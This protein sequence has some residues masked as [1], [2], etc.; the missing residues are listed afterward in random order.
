MCSSALVWRPAAHPALRLPPLTGHR[1][2][3]ESWFCPCGVLAASFHTEN[4]IRIKRHMKTMGVAHT[5]R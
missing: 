3:P 5:F 2:G 1:E 4:D